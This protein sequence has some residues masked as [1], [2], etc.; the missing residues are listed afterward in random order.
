ME[1]LSLALRTIDLAPMPALYRTSYQLTIVNLA[2]DPVITYAIA[3]EISFIPH[4]RFAPE[5]RVIAAFDMSSHPIH[6]ETG[7]EAIH[8]TKRLESLF[9]VKQVAHDQNPIKARASAS[10]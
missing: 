10:E 3:P 4:E 6:D 2:Q 1:R 8:L 7:I 9:A 5:P